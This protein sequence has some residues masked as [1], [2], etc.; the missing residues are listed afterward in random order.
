MTEK[1]KAIVNF[2]AEQIKLPAKK[3]EEEMKSALE[4]ARKAEGH[5]AKAF[6]EDYPYEK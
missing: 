4:V 1:T 6:W 5:I 3:V 2:I